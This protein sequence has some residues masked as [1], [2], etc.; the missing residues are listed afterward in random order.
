MNTLLKLKLRVV[1][2]QL[3]ALLKRNLRDAL[4][5]ENV[6]SN[7]SSQFLLVAGI[8]GRNQEFYMKGE[9]S[10]KNSTSKTVHLQHIKER[11]RSKKISELLLLDV[12]KTSF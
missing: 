6:Y 7:F 9:V 5:S 12:L 3:E 8:Q 11:S 10:W 2:I 4:F 1:T